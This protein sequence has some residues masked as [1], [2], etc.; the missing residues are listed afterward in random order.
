M[1]V[2]IYIYMY[3]YIPTNNFVIHSDNNTFG[4]FNRFKI[5]YFLYFKQNSGI[6]TAWGL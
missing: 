6:L 5:V 4:R 3:I 2:Y 1:Y